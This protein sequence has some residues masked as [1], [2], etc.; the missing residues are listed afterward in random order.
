[1]SRVIAIKHREPKRDDW[2]PVSTPR[3]FQLVDRR[4]P[5]P[6]R[7]LVARATFAATLDEAAALIERDHGIRM[8]PSGARRGNYIYPKD[9]KIV[10]A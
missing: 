4:I 5:Y 6:D 1:M 8:G 7:N 10:R 2:E 9:I 3:G